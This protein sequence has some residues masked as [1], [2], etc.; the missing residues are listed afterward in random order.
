MNKTLLTFLIPLIATSIYASENPCIQEDKNP[1]FSGFVIVPEDNQRDEHSLSG[2]D[3]QISMR[4]NEPG[5]DNFALLPLELKVKI[6]KESQP[7][8]LQLSKLRGISKDFVTAVDKIQNISAVHSYRQLLTDKCYIGDCQ[9]LSCL[10][11]E[12]PKTFEL[13]ATQFINLNVTSYLRRFVAFQT[14]FDDLLSIKDQSRLPYIFD[15]CKRSK[16]EFCEFIARFYKE[17]DRYDRL[18]DLTCVIDFIQENKVTKT[19]HILK[20]IETFRYYAQWGE[21]QK[22][23][24]YFEENPEAIEKF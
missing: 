24:N 7:D 3:N 2:N 8:F 19:P 13:Y 1:I 4:I 11:A 20:V 18:E 21:L 9:K 12:Y 17:C 23:I 22:A 5:K 6:L 10:A 14:F 16:I 15:G